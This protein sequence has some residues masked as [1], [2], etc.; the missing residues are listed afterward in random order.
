[1]KINLTEE[2]LNIIKKEIVLD[3]PNYDSGALYEFKLQNQIYGDLYC[4]IKKKKNNFNIRI[5]FTENNKIVMENHVIVFDKNDP[6]C[7]TDEYK[8]LL[9]YK[10]INKNKHR[11]AL[12][13]DK[14]VKVIVPVSYEAIINLCDFY[15][16][17]NLP[18]IFVDNGTFLILKNSTI[19]ETVENIDQQF[20][21]LIENTNNMIKD[22]SQN[23]Q[24]IDMS[25]FT[26]KDYNDMI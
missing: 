17:S 4:N 1:M 5:R 2:Y 14:D 26:D 23:L 9:V 22:E 25:N 15:N 12:S 7:E 18:C 8:K 21:N 10:K 16:D 19:N 13:I 20:N 11:L 3:T 6:F 24:G